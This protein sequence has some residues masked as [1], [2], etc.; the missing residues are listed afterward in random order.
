MKNIWVEKT[1]G[2]LWEKM[3]EC[4]KCHLSLLTE[5]MVYQKIK[6]NWNSQ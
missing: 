3:R 1:N 6:I 5:G 4:R 2:K